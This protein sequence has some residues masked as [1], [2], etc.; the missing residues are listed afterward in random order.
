MR[1]VLIVFCLLGIISGSL[2]QTLPEDRKVDWSQAGLRDTSTF[3]FLEID[4]GIYGAMGDGETSNDSI[5]AQAIS[6]LNDAGVI[7]KFPEG[8]FLFNQ[9]ISLPSNTIIKGQGA[10][11]TIFTINLGG[12]GQSI[13][14]KGYADELDTTSLVQF[15][16][17]DS[18]FIRVSDPIG[19]SIGD[20]IQI[21][22]DDSDL[23]TS[24]WAKNTVGQIVRITDIT[25]DEVTISS[26]LR[27]EYGMERK[28]YIQK[29][30]PVQN[31]G[32]E[33][34]KIERKDNTEPEQTSNV[35][36]KY[37]VNC[38]VRGI[39]SHKCTFSHIEA[40][41]SSN[42]KVSQSYFHNGFDYGVD[43]RAYGVMLHF[44]TNECLIENNIFKQLRHSMIVQ[45]GANANVFAFNYSEEPLWYTIPTD[46]AGDMVLHGNY[47]YCNLFEQNICQNI[48]ID[49]SHGPNGPDNSF[50][51]NRGAGYGI[52]FSE[53]NSPG[54]NLL[55]N[56]VTN[57]NLPYSY[58]N[59]TIL[60]AGHFIYGNY[61]K[62]VIDPLGTTMLADS[63]Y[64]YSERPDFVPLSQWVEIGNP[65]SPGTS[66]IPARDRFK[67]NEIFKDAC[68]I[69][70]TT[71]AKQNIKN[72]PGIMIFPNPIISSLKFE[73]RLFVKHIEV[74]NGLGQVQQSF[75]DPGFSK[76]IQTDNWLGHIFLVKFTFSD[77]RWIVKK[78][79]R[80]N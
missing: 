43:G 77:N 37:A 40:R 71:T 36:F 55:G 60:G 54:Q 67:A 39:E 68:E 79:I 28:P 11:N 51:R 29:I 73:S 8:N 9:S 25:D 47:P 38:W 1:Y 61:D 23:V 13:A 80:V 17:K 31:V 4:M 52:F 26:P 56:E 20:W 7:L 75:V 32:V 45:S 49:N 59:Y 53:S 58:V 19:F 21:I 44:T 18:N 2:S 72:A 15:A 50:L 62:G 63:S 42:L 12:T 5:V 33:C 14:I 76:Q 69:F 30:I 78:V 48:V 35:Y 24:V 34:L 27:L 22:Q 16:A 74:I 64:Y 66:S 70:S 41:N 10:E 65:A 3:G 46:A 57:L 6:S